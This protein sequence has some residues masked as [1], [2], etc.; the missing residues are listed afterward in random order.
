MRSKKRSLRPGRHAEATDRYLELVE[1]FP[2]RP[3][4]TDPE[5]EQAIEVVNSLIDRDDLAEDEA[6]YLDVLGDLVERYESEH[7][8]IAP[9]SDVEMLEYLIESRDTTK[10][11]VATATGIALSTISEI[12]SGRRPLNRR[13]IEVLAQHFGVKPGVFLAERPPNAISDRGG[14]ER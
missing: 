7:H 3:I 14:K 13:H 4:R 8:P 10:S 6:D 5:L 9:V 1:R 11:K 12:L 2:L